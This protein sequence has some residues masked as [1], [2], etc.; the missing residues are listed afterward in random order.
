MINNINDEFN[1]V[2][3]QIWSLTDELAE[4]AARIA[5]IRVAVKFCEKIEDKLVD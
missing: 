5:D 2:D 1:L 3:T 4:L